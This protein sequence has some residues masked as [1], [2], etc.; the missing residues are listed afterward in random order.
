ML[1]P[2][3]LYDLNPVQNIVAD[4]VGEPGNRTFFLQGSAG[5]SLVTL[6]MDKE[7]VANLANS[8]LQLLEELEEK[9]PDLSPTQ[10]PSGIPQAEH[11]ID[12]DFRV[13]QLIIGYNEKNDMIWLIAKA[14]IITE[15]GTA[16]DPRRKDVPTVRLVAT[17]DQMRAMSEHAIDVISHGRPICP[18][19]DRPIN[20]DGHFC[21]KT[22]GHAVPIFFN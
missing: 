18:L 21:P 20:A 3:Y 9:Y 13:G 22:D 4:A 1:M 17:R 8:V 10:E 16:V 5:T 6:V 19:C 14:L 15:S 12:P 7:E 2:T 11:P